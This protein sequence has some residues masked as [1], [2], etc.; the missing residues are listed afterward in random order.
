[1]KQSFAFIPPVCLVY[2]RWGY[3]YPQPSLHYDKNDLGHSKYLRNIP[4][5]GSFPVGK[6]VQLAYLY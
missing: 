5:E 3:L 2:V 6:I 1:M 4:D